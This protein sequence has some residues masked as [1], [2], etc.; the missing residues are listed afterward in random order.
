MLSYGLCIALPISL[1]ISRILTLFT[2]E[3]E[4]GET[5]HNNLGP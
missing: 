2:G 3:H 4:V 1:N 5:V